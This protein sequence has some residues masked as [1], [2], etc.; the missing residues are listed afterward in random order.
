MR[1]SYGHGHKTEES[2]VEMTFQGNQMRF[3]LY[4]EQT[5]EQMGVD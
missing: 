2:T 1:C 5:Y 4:N 3:L